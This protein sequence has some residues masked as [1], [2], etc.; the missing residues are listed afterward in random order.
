MAKPR[1]RGTAL[2]ETPQ[3]ILVALEGN[4]D[5]LLLPGGGVEKG[6]SGLE[7]AVRELYEEAKLKAVLAVPLFRFNSSYNQH[8][9]Y[10]V[11]ATGQ[12]ALGQEVN[13]LGGYKDGQLTPI[14]AKS[15]FEALPADRLSPSV[16]AIIKLY[17][18]RR[19]EASD[20]FAA[21]DSASDFKDYTYADVDEIG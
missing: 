10:Y 12:P 19:Q 6:E 5:N 8:F 15:G 21:L 4:G 16:Q 2:V 17:Q 11:R 20:W 3:G 9:V 1:D 14:A 13:Y 18:Q 7:A